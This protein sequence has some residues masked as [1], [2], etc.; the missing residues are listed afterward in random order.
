MISGFHRLPSCQAEAEG[1]GD[2]LVAA[3]LIPH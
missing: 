2:V 1:K 3:R